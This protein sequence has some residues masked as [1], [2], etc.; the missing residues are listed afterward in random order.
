MLQYWIAS[1]RSLGEALIEKAACQQADEASS[2][3]ERAQVL[4]TEAASKISLIEHPHQWAELQSQLARCPV[5]A[6]G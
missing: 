5:E 3:L 2:T 6:N 4:L 1:R